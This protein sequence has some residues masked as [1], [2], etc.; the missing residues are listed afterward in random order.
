MTDSE[1]VDLLLSILDSPYANF[2]T[3]Q[4][5][6]SGI[7][8]MAS[9]PTTSGAQQERISTLLASY[10]TNPDLEIQQRAVEF[11]NLFALGD[12]RAG[13]LERMPAPEIKATVMGYGKSHRNG[14]STY[15]T[16]SAC[17][18]R[19]REQKSGISTTRKGRSLHES[20][21]Q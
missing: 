7:T 13:V 16:H 20:A 14:P 6:F 10:S 9:R 8:K 12:I 18:N 17:Q 11:S 5:V 2:L 15:F 19:E 1:I 4:F 21:N 3:R